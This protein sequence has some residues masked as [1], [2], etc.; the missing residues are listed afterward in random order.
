MVR[1]LEGNIVGL[2]RVPKIVINTIWVREVACSTDRC[3]SS[4]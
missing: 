1:K 2:G 3:L 4:A